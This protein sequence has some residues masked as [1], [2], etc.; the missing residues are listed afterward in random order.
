MWNSDI[1]RDVQLVQVNSNCFPVRKRNLVEI[2]E[3][4]EIQ[5]GAVAESSRA[6]STESD[7]QPFYISAEGCIN[8]V[9]W[10]SSYFGMWDVREFTAFQFIIEVDIIELF[11]ATIL[12]VNVESFG[13]KL[14]AVCEGVIVYR[15]HSPGFSS[16][17]PVEHFAQDIFV[18]GVGMREVNE[19]RKFW[20]TRDHTGLGG[21]VFGQVAKS[22]NENILLLVP[23][24]R[25]TKSSRVFDRR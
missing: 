18:Q 16:G 19:F 15:P 11:G 13:V 6:L 9:H 24:P 4:T 23:L 25:V 5:H 8:I 20:L 14:E 2:C 10:N 22:I 12:R 17:F 1:I 7:R 21:P 3:V